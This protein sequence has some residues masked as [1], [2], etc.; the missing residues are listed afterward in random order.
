MVLL[1]FALC[2]AGFEPLSWRRDQGP[3]LKTKGR[4]VFLGGIKTSAAAQNRLGWA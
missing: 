1:P 2:R 3:S 4:S